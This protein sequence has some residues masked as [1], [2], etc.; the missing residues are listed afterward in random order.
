MIGSAAVKASP[1]RASELFRPRE[2]RFVIGLMGEYRPWEM[3]SLGLSCPTASVW[4]MKKTCSYTNR[5]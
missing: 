2:L 1:R 5:R 3:S 4:N